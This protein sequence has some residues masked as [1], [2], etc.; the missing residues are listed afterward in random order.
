MLNQI[1]LIALILVNT[2]LSAVIN[3]INKADSVWTSNGAD[4]K[5]INDFLLSNG[6]F[7][8][9]KYSRLVLKYSSFSDYSKSKNESEA[10]SKRNLHIYLLEKKSYAESYV[11]FKTQSKRAC[12]IV[13]VFKMFEKQYDVS[14][15]EFRQSNLPIW[16]GSDR[17]LSM[18]EFIDLAKKLDKANDENNIELYLDHYMSLYKHSNVDRSRLLAFLKAES[19][20]NQIPARVNKPRERFL[21]DSINTND[22]DEVIDLVVKIDERNPI[23]KYTYIDSAEELDLAE[24]NIS[25]LDKS[26]SYLRSLKRLDLTSNEFVSIEVKSFSYL[27]SLT[28]LVLDMNQIVFVRNEAFHG[29]AKLTM[30]SL[31]DNHI[32]VLEKYAF[33]GLNSLKYLFLCNNQIKVIDYVAFWSLN[34][35]VTLSLVRIN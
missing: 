26:L 12:D 34:K 10:E 22:F 29:L 16:L 31:R 3:T 27:A 32:F 20:L 15:S 24:R 30:L 6:D 4:F 7:D 25:R 8:R 18:T 23:L 28:S 14:L 2:Q 19:L 13:D 1:I 17:N 9:D 11:S 21:S 35:L 33:N 5:K